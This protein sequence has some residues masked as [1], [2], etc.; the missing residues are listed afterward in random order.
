MSWINRD[1]PSE[2]PLPS[3]G[4]GVNDDDDVINLGV[5]AMTKPLPALCE[6]RDVLTKPSPPE[7]VSDDLYVALPFSGCWCV[8]RKLV[9][10]EILVGTAKN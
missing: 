5:A 3:R 6:T 10:F 9:R 7:M 4:V 2:G 8:L 1:D